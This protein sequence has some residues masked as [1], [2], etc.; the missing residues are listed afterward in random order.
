MDTKQFL[1]FLGK[2]EK[3]K[4][5]TRHSY[6]ADGTHEVVASHTWRLAVMAMLLEREFPALDMDKVIRMCLIHDWGE[7]VTGDIPSFDKT[8]EHEDIETQAV[9]GLI[10]TLPKELYQDMAVLFEE[11]DALE[12]PE[13]RFYKALDKLEAVISHNESDIS[14]W[15]PIEYDLQMTAATEEVKGFPFLE[16]LREQMKQDTKE[17]I[18]KAGTQHAD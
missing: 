15:I 14:T 2:I 13:A 10:R 8:K 1:I 17:K 7:A 16:Q 9:E 4:S 6:T 12:T 18:A 11:M 3:L 5:N